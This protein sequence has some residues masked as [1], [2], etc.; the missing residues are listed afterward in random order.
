M[1]TRYRLIVLAAVVTVLLA[2]SHSFGLRDLLSSEFV[3]RQ[4]SEHLVT[5]LLVF[6]LLFALGNLIHIPGLLFLAAAVLALGRFWGGLA[7]YF[8]ATLSCLSTF[9]LIRALG[10]DALRELPGRRARQVFAQLDAHPVRSVALLRLLLQTSPPLNYA[11]ALSGVRF[12][13]YAIGT[14]LALPVPIAVYSLF[15]EQLA[16]LLKT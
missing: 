9:W 4:F 3:R 10:G 2:L 8:A 16:R 11:L 12:R 14:V 13:A 5:G 6:T 7:T 1:Q 15:F